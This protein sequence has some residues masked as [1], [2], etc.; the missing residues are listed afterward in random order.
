ML[1]VKA[2]QFVAAPADEAS[3]PLYG[4]GLLF[5]AP[6]WF[7]ENAAVEM[8]ANLDSLPYEE[9]WDFTPPVPLNWDA[10]I[11][12]SWGDLVELGNYI[13]TA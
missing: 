6:E 4:D 10:K 1:C 7:A 8:K 2:L 9:A 3:N 12:S 11:G 5:Y 13:E